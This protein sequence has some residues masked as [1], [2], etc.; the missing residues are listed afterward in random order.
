MLK[1]RILSFVLGE[2]LEIIIFVFMSHILNNSPDI[3]IFLVIFKCIFKFYHSSLFS[4]NFLLSSLSISKM[5]VCLLNIPFD[6]YVE[7]NHFVISQS[8]AG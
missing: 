6:T 8:C 1:V 5:F 2:I 3:N 7:V 4:V